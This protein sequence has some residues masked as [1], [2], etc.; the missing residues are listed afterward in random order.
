MSQRA[1]GS[2]TSIVVVQNSQQQVGSFTKCETFEVTPDAEIK[3]SDFLGESTSD[4]DMQHHGYDFK[5][6]IHEQD[7]KAIA[8]YNNIAAA[9]EAGVLLPDME[10]MAITQYPDPAQGIV[11]EILQDVVIKLD[12]R[13]FSGR[14]EYLKNAFS[15]FAKRKITQ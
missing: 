8:F 10:V 7:S 13:A 15:G 1:K 4:G 12:S 2:N 6:T 14:K 9:S 3:K 11:T 5:F